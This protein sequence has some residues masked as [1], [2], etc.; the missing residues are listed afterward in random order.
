MR[1]DCRD[2]S[3]LPFTAAAQTPPQPPPDPP[4]RRPSMVGSINDASIQ[5]QLR[6]RFDSAVDLDSPDRAEFFYPKCGCYRDL[7]T[8][9]PAYDPEAP[10][11][12]PGIATEVNAQNL[13]A[14]AEYAVSD[15]LPVFGKLPIRW[16]QPQEFAA[17]SGSF[18][19]HSGLS[20]L[21]AGVKLGLLASDMSA[22]TLQLQATLSST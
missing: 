22:L 13:Y 4:K 14:M 18:D 5:S 11:P 16:V 21:R 6:I 19:N 15:R 7:P 3:L 2:G 12:G 20:D 9:H 17:G 1:A 8:T 10:G